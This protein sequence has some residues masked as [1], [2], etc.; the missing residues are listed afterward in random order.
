MNK[1]FNELR[2]KEEKHYI[3]KTNIIDK[4]KPLF[5][6]LHLQHLSV[7]KAN[8]LKELYELE[9]KYIS[10]IC[11]LN[12]FIRK[13]FMKQYLNGEDQ[14]KVVDNFWKYFSD[15]LERKTPSPRLKKF[16][17]DNIQSS[18]LKINNNKSVCTYGKKFIVTIGIDKYVQWTP[19]NNAVNDSIAV[20]NKFKESFNFEGYNVSD[21]QVTKD[22]IEK[23]IKNDLPLQTSLNDLLVISFHG[24]GHTARVRKQP[25]GFL[26]PITAQKPPLLHE[27]ICISE[28][29]TW[30]NYISCRH[31][32]LLFDCCFSGFSAIRSDMKVNR[33]TSVMIQQTCRVAINAGTHRQKVLD[34]GWGKHSVFTGSLLNAECLTKRE[35]TITELYNEIAS[36]V[37]QI[38]EQTPTMGRLPGDMGGELYIG[39]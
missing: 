14:E 10:E 25:R 4:L 31:V 29:I 38:A 17:S 1:Q 33:R 2:K 11:I 15:K 21:G 20:L 18:L 36:K 6:D 26:V 27:L 22:L 39:L 13:G 24:H 8:S 5:I 23:M 35:V 3:I 34:G 19:L 16:R 28:L 9:K 32:L 30:L 37:T 7:S 12:V